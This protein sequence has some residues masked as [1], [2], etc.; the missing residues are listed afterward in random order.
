MVVVAVQRQRRR[1]NPTLDSLTEGAKRPRLHRAP[2]CTSTTPT[3][4]S[5]RASCTTRPA[6]RS[7]TCASRRRRRASS[8][9][10]RS[11]PSD[12]GEPHTQE[13]LLLGKG[14]RGRKLGSVEAMALARVERVHRAVAHRV[15]L[16]HRR[17]PR[18][19]LA[20]VREP[21]RRAAQPRLH[22]RGDPPRGAQLRRRQGPDDGKLRLEEKGTVYNEM[23][24]TYEAPETEPVARRRAPRLRRDA[25]ARARLRRLSRRRFAR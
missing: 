20:G 9:S 12:K 15:S 17:R 8:G 23:V 18:R 4:R 13:H 6:S 2:R 16:P 10:T 14:D 11:R 22:R 25:S 24:R 7:T 19:V 3:S 21:A 1:L 5:A